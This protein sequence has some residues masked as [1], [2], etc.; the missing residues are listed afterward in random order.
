MKL[1]DI[2]GD[3]A[4]DVLADIIEPSAEI[5]ADENVKNAAR[6]GNKVAAVKHILKDH[7]T[8]IFAILA[9]TEGITADEYRAKTNLAT[10][11]AEL[12][13]MLNDPALTSLFQS[14]GQEMAAEPFGSAMGNI[15]DSEN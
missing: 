8:A 14:Q 3:R 1:S 2:K 10:L 15:E 4:L 13:E 7:K 5:M 11:P 9:A 12:L 6:A